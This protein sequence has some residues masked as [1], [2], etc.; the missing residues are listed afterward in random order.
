MGSPW[1]GQVDPSGRIAWKR[2]RFVQSELLRLAGRWIRVKVTPISEDTAKRLAYWFA[3]VVPLVAER[4]GY[5][6]SQTHAL[7]VA[8]CFGVIHDKVT[9]RQVPNQ[10]STSALN[11]AHWHELIDW[12]GPW[13][14]RTYGLSIPPPRSAAAQQLEEAVSQ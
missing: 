11:G 9:G 6:K 12:V 7:L 2:T 4:T 1:I 3:V 13:A 10:A 8:N 5:T 14:L